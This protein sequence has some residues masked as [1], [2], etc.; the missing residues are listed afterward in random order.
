[1]AHDPELADRIRALLA[2]ESGVTEQ[3]MFGGRA[4]M[5]RG[6]L[7]IAASGQG[8]VLVRV[9]PAEADRLLAR[10]KAEV[11][12]MRGRPMT[13]WLRVPVEALTTKRQLA[14]WVSIGS[15]YAHSLP[16]KRRRPRSG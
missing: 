11:A 15:T 12:I 13:G 8:G 10:S 1:V 4:F 6:N 16:P 2:D 7:A 9:D 3:S 5:V 14:R